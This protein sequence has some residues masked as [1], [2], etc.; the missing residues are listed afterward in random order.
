MIFNFLRSLIAIWWTCKQVRRDRHYFHLLLD[1]EIMYGNSIAKLYKIFFR[2]MY[3]V[4]NK[5]MAMG[6]FFAT[7]AITAVCAE[8]VGL[9]VE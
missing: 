6:R 3:F 4:N 1:H 8:L 9:R 7:S 5:L 2:E